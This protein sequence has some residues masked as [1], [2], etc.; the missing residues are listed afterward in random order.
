MKNDSIVDRIDLLNKKS[1]IKKDAITWTD[2]F[3]TI[4]CGVSFFLT[5]W[6]IFS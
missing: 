5:L 4:I 2:V 6:V 3:Y 1:E